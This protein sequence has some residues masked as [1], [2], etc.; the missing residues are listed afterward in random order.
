MNR[1]EVENYA[2]QMPTV[3]QQYFHGLIETKSTACYSFLKG[4]FLAIFIP[5]GTNLDD[6]TVKELH[7]IAQKK[8]DELEAEQANQ[9]KNPF[10]ALFLGVNQ[11]LTQKGLSLILDIDLSKLSVLERKKVGDAMML[12]GIYFKC[13]TPIADIALDIYKDIYNSRN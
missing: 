10:K 6:Y 8:S 4:D 1:T 13:E 12:A 2:K 3:T 7:G 11:G 9:K 5:E